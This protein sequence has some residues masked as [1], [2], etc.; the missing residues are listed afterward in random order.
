[1]KSEECFRKI[2]NQI[3]YE[4]DSK[5]K[6]NRSLAI[7]GIRE[8]NHLCYQVSDIAFNFSDIA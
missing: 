6:S 3:H 7:S 5:V 4:I 8:T 1:M 2:I